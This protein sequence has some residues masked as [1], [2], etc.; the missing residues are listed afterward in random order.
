MSE[1]L[2]A[3]TRS[4]P[5]NQSGQKAPP[6]TPP[7]RYPV[8]PRCSGGKIVIAG[9]QRASF[10]PDVPAMK[11]P[12]LLSLA[13]VSVLAVT[14]GLRAEPQSLPAPFAAVGRI[15]RADARLDALV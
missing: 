3:P 14:A 5:R 7:A 10:N 8:S 2:Y 9:H 13:L 11:F 12:R 1:G 15:E 4:K 6:T